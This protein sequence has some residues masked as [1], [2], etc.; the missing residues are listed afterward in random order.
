M[1]TIKPTAEMHVDW[2]RIFEAHHATMKP[3]RK[4][5]TEVN[6]YFINKYA[7]QVFNDAS[8]Q[9]IIALN[10]TENAFYCNKLPNII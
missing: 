7:N 5:G 8:F 3:N 4:T 6:Q 9:E 10:I 1:L 2:K